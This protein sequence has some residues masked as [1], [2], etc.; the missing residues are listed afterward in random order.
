MS[1]V[2]FLIFD[3]L[4]REISARVN[5]FVRS[6]SGRTAEKRR[7]LA[8]S[9]MRG[10]LSCGARLDRLA[11]DIRRRPRRQYCGVCELR[12]ERSETRGRP[13][14]DYAKRCPIISRATWLAIRS[15]RLD[16]FGILRHREQSEAIQTRVSN[17]GLGDTQKQV[18]QFPVR[19]CER[20]EAIQGPQY[21]RLG[22]WRR[23]CCGPWIASS[24]G[25]L[26]M[27]DGSPLT[28]SLR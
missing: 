7:N 5:R 28:R 4:W 18:S 12:R 16:Y 17:C 22:C 21:D 9:K 27:T 1:S 10:F 8:R 26:A 6:A 13:R 11:I 20:S 14:C 24:Q 25:L 19:H 23:A 3:G 15:H 2:G